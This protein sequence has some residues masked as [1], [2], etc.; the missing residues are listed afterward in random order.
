VTAAVIYTVAKGAHRNVCRAW[1]YSGD[2]DQYTW[3]YASKRGVELIG[4]NLNAWGATVSHETRRNT[5]NEM[6]VAMSMCFTTDQTVSLEPDALDVSGE[7]FYLTLDACRA[8]L[9]RNEP[10][11]FTPEC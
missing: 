4:V 9:K 2:V 7:R 8:A 11:T 10:V 3:S 5:G 1:T 6:S